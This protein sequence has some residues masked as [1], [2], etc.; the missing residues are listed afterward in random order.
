MNVSETEMCELN[1]GIGMM[2]RELIRRVIAPIMA[3]R[4]SSCWSSSR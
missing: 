3:K 1:L 2:I 4:K